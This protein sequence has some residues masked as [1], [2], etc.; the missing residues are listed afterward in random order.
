M[1]AGRPSAYNEEI[2]DRICE[3]MV[4][5]NDLVSICADP[6]MPHRS[7]VYRWLA[8]NPDFAT[9]VAR[10][11]EGLAD[12]LDW[13]IGQEAD[14]CTNENAQA[15][16]VKIWALQWRA[17]KLAPKKYGIKVAQEHSG[18]DGSPIRTQAEPIDDVEIARRIAFLLA[19]GHQAM[20]QETK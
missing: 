6:C 11:R 8:A 15:T 16:R 10:A 14:A 18:P 2:A 12:F 13:R 1:S 3:A 20:K 5:G 17:S 19:K 9:R 7:T 4:D